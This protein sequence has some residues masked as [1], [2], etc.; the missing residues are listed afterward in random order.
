VEIGVADD[1][2][3]AIEVWAGLFLRRAATPVPSAPA[4]TREHFRRAEMCRDLAV[5]RV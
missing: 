3:G 1:D 4:V 5:F 2:E